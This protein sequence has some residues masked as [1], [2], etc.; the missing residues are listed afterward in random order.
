M[1]K[2]LTLILCLLLPT[3][4]LAEERTVPIA[5]EQ[6][7]I[8][9]EEGKTTTEIKPLEGEGVLVVPDDKYS[10]HGMTP[11]TFDQIKNMYPQEIESEPDPSNPGE[12]WDYY[13]IKRDIIGP[14]GNV[15]GVE[16][17]AGT[18]RSGARPHFADLMFDWRY[19]TLR[20]GNIHDGSSYH[21]YKYSYPSNPISTPFPVTD[22]LRFIWP[23]NPRHGYLHRASSGH[24]G[25]SNLNPGDPIWYAMTTEKFTR[26]TNIVEE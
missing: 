13:L 20:Y 16:L 4:L 15:I 23:S 2:Y 6:V 19:N 22:G 18:S 24:A 3:I 1:I 10:E 26:V 5:D 14:Y 12:S 8:K 7:L 25:Y 21:S 17:L 9:V 11:L